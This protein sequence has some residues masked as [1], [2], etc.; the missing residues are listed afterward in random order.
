MDISSLSVPDPRQDQFWSV[1]PWLVVD[2][3][4]LK[5]VLFHYL[6]TPRIVGILPVLDDILELLF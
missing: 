1:D 6:R 4:R 3:L 2:S 5:S